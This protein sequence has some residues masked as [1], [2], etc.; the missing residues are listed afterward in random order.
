M[1]AEEMRSEL[2]KTAFR[3]GK[4]QMGFRLSELTPGEFM[5]I[6]AIHK[7]MKQQPEAA[8]ISVTELA[9]RTWSS[10]P[11][12]SRSLRGIEVRNLIVRTVDP[13]NRRKTFVRLTPEGEAL[14]MGMWEN[15]NSYFDIVSQTMGEEKM[16]AFLAL[17]NEL[18]DVMEA[19]L[20]NMTDTDPKGENKEHGKTI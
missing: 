11:A 7:Y 10:L 8:G 16:V 18:T 2:V 9:R 3:F 5:T 4:M 17:W 15:W 14:R 20:K 12:M 13:E 1:T 19:E 6:Q